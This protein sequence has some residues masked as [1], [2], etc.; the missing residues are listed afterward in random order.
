[1]PT[2]RPPKNYVPLRS[3]IPPEMDEALDAFVAATGLAK[4]SLIRSALAE[5]L[6]ELNLLP[7]HPSIP[8]ALTT[9]STND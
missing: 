5:K 8:L 9:R 3:S 6:V 4:A 7:S 1:M 2:G